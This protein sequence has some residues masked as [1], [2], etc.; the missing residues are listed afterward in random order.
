MY[1]L[2]YDGMG[3]KI[4]LG[5][6]SRQIGYRRKSTFPRNANNRL[7]WNKIWYI[8]T[9]SIGTF[10]MTESRRQNERLK[11]KHIA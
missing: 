10:R 6:Q 2:R 5:E 11:G 4:Y 7:H 1:A 9:A 3:F 8:A